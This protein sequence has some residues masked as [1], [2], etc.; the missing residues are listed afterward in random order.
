MNNQNKSLYFLYFSRNSLLLHVISLLRNIKAEKSLW[1]STTIS[2]NGEK[3]KL[4]STSRRK[5]GTSGIA[6]GITDIATS[7]SWLSTKTAVSFWW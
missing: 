3:N 6:I 2:A 4:L 1:Q 5:D 7:T